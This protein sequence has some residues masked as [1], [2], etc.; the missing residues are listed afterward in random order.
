[1]GRD[2]KP[3]CG[4]SVSPAFGSSS[5]NTQWNFVKPSAAWQCPVGQCKPVFR[6]SRLLH[7]AKQERRLKTYSVLRKTQGTAYFD[8]SIRKAGLTLLLTP[9]SAA[10]LL[11]CNRPFW[12]VPAAGQ[13]ISVQ[14]PPLSSFHRL[15]AAK[16]D[17]DQGGSFYLRACTVTP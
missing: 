16:L 4:S 15:K 1:M 7:S 2:Q 12:A 13:F 11:L 17:L 6:L 5:Q 10:A 3:L 8:Y 9:G 14:L